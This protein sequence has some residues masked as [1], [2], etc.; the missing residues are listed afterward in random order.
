MRSLAEAEVWAAVPDLQVTSVGL[1]PG[2][3]RILQDLVVELRP[4]GM[5]VLFRPVGARERTLVGRATTSHPDC[6]AASNLTLP[7]A[8]TNRAYT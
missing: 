3:V 6:T 7:R 5:A 4:A 2:K 8:A 1:H